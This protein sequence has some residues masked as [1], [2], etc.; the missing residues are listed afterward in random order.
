MLQLWRNLMRMT[1]AWLFMVVWPIAISFRFVMYSVIICC[2][3]CCCCCQWINRLIDCL[4]TL[5][6]RGMYCWN[7]CTSSADLFCCSSSRFVTLSVAATAA[8]CHWARRTSPRRFL[9]RF[10]IRWQSSWR[11]TAPDLVRR[12]TSRLLHQLLPCGDHC[13]DLRSPCVSDLCFCDFG[14]LLTARASIIGWKCSHPAIWIGG[15]NI[16]C[17]PLLLLPVVKKLVFLFSDITMYAHL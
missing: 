1:N 11:R 2:W 12:Q 17:A 15:N 9:Q 14:L 4:R 10:Q 6:C 13:S 7:V 3:W 16:C 8:T 5:W